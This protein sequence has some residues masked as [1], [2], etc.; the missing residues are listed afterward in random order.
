MI[1]ME[2]VRSSQASRAIVGA[3]HLITRGIGSCCR[4]PSRARISSDLSVTG[5]TQLCTSES[6]GEPRWELVQ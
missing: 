3:L 6:E 4:A 5:I 1:G 2:T